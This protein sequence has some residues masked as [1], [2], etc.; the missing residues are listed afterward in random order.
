MSTP[1]FAALAI[2]LK[3]A[4]GVEIAKA[5]GL[6]ATKTLIALYRLSWTVSSI[7]K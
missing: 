2:A 1:F 6:D 5:H 3:T 7:I 4:E